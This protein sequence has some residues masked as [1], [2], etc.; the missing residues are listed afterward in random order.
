M[1]ITYSKRSHYA[2]DDIIG[3]YYSGHKNVTFLLP[4]LRLIFLDQIT[5]SPKHLNIGKIAN[6]LW[7][8]V[9]NF[10]FIK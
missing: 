3:K 8:A 7:M 5:N 9:R 1:F 4:E 2:G 6:F 10:D